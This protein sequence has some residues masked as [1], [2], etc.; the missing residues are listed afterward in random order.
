MMLNTLHDLMNRE[1]AKSISMSRRC[2]FSTIF[3][4]AKK[5]KF[6]F[7]NRNNPVYIFH[8]PPCNSQGKRKLSICAGVLFKKK[9]VKE[10]NRT[11]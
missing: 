1:L 10:A 8:L 5:S 9:T 7:E 6:F 2:D 4:F 11:N 3:K